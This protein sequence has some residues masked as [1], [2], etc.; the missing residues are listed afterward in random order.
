MDDTFNSGEKNAGQESH[1][2]VDWQHVWKSVQDVGSQAGHA[3]KK[4]VDQIDTKELGEKAKHVASEGLKVARGQSDNRQANEISDAA[5]K[6][7]PGAGLIRQGAVIAH[8]TGA[9]GK[10]LEGKKGPL[11]AP[12]DRTMREAGKEAIGSAIP[13]PGGVF[14]NE[15]LNRTG[16]KDKVINTAVDAVKNHDGRQGSSSKEHVI[17]VDSKGQ[18]TAGEHLPKV[19]IEDKKPGQILDTAKEKIGNFFHSFHKPEIVETKKN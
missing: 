18:H 15:L 1:K 12:S 7:I 5:S 10:V 16:V 6:Y 13:I 17:P 14:A 9:E 4:Q 19:I 8:E 11:H 3:I 2:S